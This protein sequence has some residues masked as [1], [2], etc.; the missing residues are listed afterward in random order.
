MKH[1]KNVLIGIVCA[2]F[3]AGVLAVTLAPFAIAG[4]VA[5]EAASYLKRH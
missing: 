1:L 3:L 4:Y 5:I 2:V